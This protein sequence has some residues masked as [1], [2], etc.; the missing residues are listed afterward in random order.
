MSLLFRAAVL[1]GIAYLITRS[2]S[3]NSPRRAMQDGRAD[4]VRDVNPDEHVWPTTDARQP[5][6]ATIDPGS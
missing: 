1:G 5:A 4:R 6:G 2:M 3:S